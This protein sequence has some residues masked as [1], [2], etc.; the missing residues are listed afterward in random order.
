MEK[1]IEVTI[2]FRAYGLGV[3]RALEGFGGEDREYYGPKP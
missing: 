1:Q 2:S 3:F